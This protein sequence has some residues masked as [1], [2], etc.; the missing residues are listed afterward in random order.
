MNTQAS[1]RQEGVTRPIFCIQVSHN[2]FCISLNVV[3]SPAAPQRQKRNINCLSSSEQLEAAVLSQ[4][5]TIFCSLLL[6][7][8]NQLDKNSSSSRLS[9]RIVNECSLHSCIELESLTVC[10]AD[11]RTGGKGVAKNGCQ[12]SQN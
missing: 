5:I 12:T 2:I 1:S 8:C 4:C 9:L 10:E 7:L 6:L 11:G 3:S